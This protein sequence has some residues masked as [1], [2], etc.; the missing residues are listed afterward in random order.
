MAGASVLTAILPF[1]TGA[2]GA[3]VGA[4]LLGFIG[5]LLYFVTESFA[6]TAILAVTGGSIGFVIGFFGSYVSWMLVS[7]IVMLENVR[8]V[9][10]LRRSRQLVKRSFATAIGAALIMFVIPAVIAGLIS[11]V[12]NISA[13]AFDPKPKTEPEAT[14][15]TA[16]IENAAATTSEGKKDTVFGY[17]INEPTRNPVRFE[18]RDMRGTV[19]KTALESMIQIL[20]LPMQIF[21]FSFSA[22]IVALLYLKTRL[23][24]GESMNDLIERFEDDGRPRKKWQERVR[25]RLIQSGRISSKPSNPE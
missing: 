10:A 17:T 7:P 3:I 1:V 9:E 5:G 2:I 6:P 8:V 22:I 25:Q 15:Q 11:F 18:D 13:K 14:S 4:I 20:W 19:R 12:V 16:E 23:A 21:V 24:G